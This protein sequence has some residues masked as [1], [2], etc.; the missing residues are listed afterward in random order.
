MFNKV[1]MAILCG[2]LD[3]A[4]ARGVDSD[5]EP[6]LG[7]LKKEDLVGFDH[8]RYE[9]D[10]IALM[11]SHLER[12]NCVFLD[13]DVEFSLVVGISGVYLDIAHSG[14]NP[15]AA[16]GLNI[17]GETLAVFAHEHD[18]GSM[19]DGDLIHTITEDWPNYHGAQLSK[20]YKHTFIYRFEYRSDGS[21]SFLEIEALYRSAFDYMGTLLWIGNDNKLNYKDPRFELRETVL[22]SDVISGDHGLEKYTHYFAFCFEYFSDIPGDTTDEQIHLEDEGYKYMRSLFSMSDHHR[23]SGS[24]DPAFELS[25]TE[26]A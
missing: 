23:L 10:A 15:V 12:A 17:S 8:F 7:K 6:H 16:V 19:S 3:L 13:S 22:T 20:Q 26:P 4:A 14:G 9:I 5:F 18:E 2:C 25:H 11:L 21:P 24:D 1:Q